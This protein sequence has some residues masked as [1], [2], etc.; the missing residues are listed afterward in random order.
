MSSAK[1]EPSPSLAARINSVSVWTNITWTIA[2]DLYR[3]SRADV[4]QIS[5]PEIIWSKQWQLTVYGCEGDLFV[6]T[7]NSHIRSREWTHLRDGFFGWHSRRWD[8]RGCSSQ[9]T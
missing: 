8:W 1:A 6:D 7:G 5:W 4:P 3:A 2:L 9:S